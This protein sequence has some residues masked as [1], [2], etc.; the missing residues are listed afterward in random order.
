MAESLR[1]GDV[2]RSSIPSDISDDVFSLDEKADIY[3]TSGMQKIE[4]NY[5]GKSCYNVYVV[6]QCHPYFIG[7]LPNAG[8]RCTYVGEFLHKTCSN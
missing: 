3:K 5:I 8:V 4:E 2:V 1:N 6:N 7:K